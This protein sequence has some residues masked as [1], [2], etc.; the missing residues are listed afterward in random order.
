MDRLHQ[1]A[2]T[3]FLSQ[4]TT[5]IIAISISFNLA[6]TDSSPQKKTFLGSYKVILAIMS[7]LPNS[8]YRSNIPWLITCSLRFQTEQ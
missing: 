5:V 6:L 3:I 4:I 7:S 2:S 1:S 8:S